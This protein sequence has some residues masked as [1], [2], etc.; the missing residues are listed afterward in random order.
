MQADDGAPLLTIGPTIEL[1]IGGSSV[2][3]NASE[4]D[5][6]TRV[7]RLQI[8]MNGTDAMFYLDCKEIES[9][10]FTVSNSGINFV[11]ILGERNVSTLEYKNF[12]DVSYKNYLEGDTNK[13]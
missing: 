12:F 10:P 5:I 1:S 9:K 13:Y 11:S 6:N 7:Q 2:S 8:C 3:F 4:I